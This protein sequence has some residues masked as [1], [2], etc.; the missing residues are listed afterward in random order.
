MYMVSFAYVKCK[1]MVIFYTVYIL[2]YIY[3]E[4][5]PYG[6]IY[7]LG[8]KHLNNNLLRQSHTFMAIVI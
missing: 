8:F 3:I 4:V 2:I 6:C 7:V 5:V 1:N